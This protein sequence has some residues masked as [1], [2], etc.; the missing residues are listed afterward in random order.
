M[1]S[2]VPKSFDPK[3]PCRLSLRSLILRTITKIGFH[4]RRDLA[5]DELDFLFNWFTKDS[6][7][8]KQLT[9]LL[10]R[11]DDV[12]PSIGDEPVFEAFLP[13][14]E[15]HLESFIFQVLFPETR[16]SFRIM[17]AFTEFLET[18]SSIFPSTRSNIYAKC[19]EKLGDDNAK[20]QRTESLI[21]ATNAFLRN[22]LDPRYFDALWIRVKKGCNDRSFDYRIACFNCLVMA[23]EKLI[24]TNHKRVSDVIKFLALLLMEQFEDET[25]NFVRSSII[26]LLD[27]YPTISCSV[28]V[29]PL[30]KTYG[31][32]SV[33]NQDF[34]VLTKLAVHPMLQRSSAL[35]MFAA[36]WNTATH[37]LEFGRA[38]MIPLLLLIKRFSFA[39]EVIKGVENSYGKSY[40][41]KQKHEFLFAELLTCIFGLHID[42]ITSP[43]HE[44]FRKVGTTSII[45]EE[46]IRFS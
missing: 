33:N 30:L 15:V 45:L 2:L 20:D 22:D 1:S 32:P 23:L 19:I 7:C 31:Y 44:L 46:C 21:L 8:F 39:K 5:Q 38:A 14:V 37:D 12:N 4:A 41:G 10:L 35:H 42:K 36:L 16:N 17:Y 34:D 40:E 28:V 18:F 13:Y 27:K 26:Y 25:K 9:T 43:L 11:K 3:C 29:P 24:D 6:N